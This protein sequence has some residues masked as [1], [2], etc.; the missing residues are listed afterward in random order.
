MP[1]CAMQKCRNHSRKTGS[2]VM[3]HRFPNDLVTRE[4]WIFACKRYLP[5]TSRVCSS[6]FS[7][8][9]YER[10][11][12]SELAGI[13]INRTLKTDVVPQF[14]YQMKL[15]SDLTEMQKRK[16]HPENSK[17]EGNKNNR[18]RVITQELNEQTMCQPGPSQGMSIIQRTYFLENEIIRNASIIFE[19]RNKREDDSTAAAVTLRSV[20]R[21]AYLYFRKNVGLPLA[22]LS[23]IRKW[24]R[25]LK[26]LPG[27]QKE[28]LSVLKGRSISMCS[29]ELLTVV[30]FD[31]IRNNGPPFQCPIITRGLAFKRKQPIF[32]DFHK[33]ITKG[34]LFE[35]INV[36][37]SRFKVIAIVSDMG[38][39][40]LSLRKNLKFPQSF[41]TNQVDVAGEVWVLADI[42]H[43]IKLLRNNFLDYGIRL[44]CGTEA[45]KWQLQQILQDKELSLTPK[46]DS[47]MHLNVSG[48][49]RQSE[50]CYA[51]LFSHHTATLLKRKLYMDNNTEDENAISDNVNCENSEIEEDIE[52]EPEE[53]KKKTADLSGSAEENALRYLA[54]YL[55]HCSKGENFMNK[56]TII[57]APDEGFLHGAAAHCTPVTSRGQT[58]LPSPFSLRIGST[59]PSSSLGCRRDRSTSSSPSR[60]APGRS[61]GPCRWV[62]RSPPMTSA[63]GSR[64]RS[65]RTPTDRSSR[66]PVCNNTHKFTFTHANT[67]CAFAAPVVN[68]L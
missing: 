1:G 51:I 20:S 60:R 43:L 32:H 4:N 64:T 34:K 52:D 48:S 3:Y 36:V 9:N 16:R 65:L 56:E 46:L 2:A 44:P 27:I 47:R 42:P 37:E 35:V 11:L 5:D 22:E 57:A 10:D 6:H 39:G 24:T 38:A 45:S 15:V 55:A 58:A 28:L 49:A 50:V 62:T 18:T 40:N 8:N 41:F 53:E 68:D 13:K 63:A 17:C 67:S 7:E 12:R 26:C 30:L 33:N 29:R 21:R 25:N 59:S 19:G 31:E 23:T 54:G 61:G 66:S 14:C